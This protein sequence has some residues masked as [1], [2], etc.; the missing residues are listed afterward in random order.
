MAE[1]SAQGRAE[2]RQALSELRNFRLK[3]QEEQIPL[4]QE[5]RQL[6][7]QLEESQQ[8]LRKLRE[9]ADSND[10]ALADLERQVNQ[11]ASTRSAAESLIEELIEEQALTPDN[12]LD[13]EHNTQYEKWKDSAPGPEKLKLSTDLLIRLTE[14]LHQSIGGGTAPT[15]IYSPDGQKISG[16]GL[17]IGPL[18]YFYSPEASGIVDT[19]DP[20]FPKLSPSPA[21]EAQRIRTVI[22]SGSG[23]VPIDATGG[24]ALALRQNSPDL[25]GEILR[26]GIWIYPILLAAL[27]TV[28]VAIT[29][30]ISVGRV[31]SSI[32]RAR[33]QF[34]EVWSSKNEAQQEKFLQHQSPLL[35]PF[36]ETLWNTRN[37]DPESR[38]DLL[39][40]RLIAIRLRLT[41]GLAAL[42]VI[43]A[44]A[45]LLGLLGTVTGMITTFQRITLFGTGDPQSLSGGI[46]EA[47]LTTKFGL[48]VAIPTFLL[49]AYL[50]RRS[51]G[52]VANLEAFS[53]QFE[54]APAPDSSSER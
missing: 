41:R 17:S 11:L 40:A 33:S 3:V 28:I 48:I 44:T 1:I 54:G 12:R 34:P 23:T 32:R 9:A 49:Y 31:R 53:R 39:Y 47:L 29:K 20:T 25:L 36:W 8:K 43:A 26:A 38:E 19:S 6:R 14:S 2:A 45:P 21:D 5:I 24:A 35:R 22:E 18:T 46:S 15:T 10:V 4:E 13:P 16:T 7:S 52:T 37:S 51:Q 50:S 27:I 42:S 30:W